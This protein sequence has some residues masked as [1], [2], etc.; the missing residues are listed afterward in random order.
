MDRMHSPAATLTC[1]YFYRQQSG[2]VHS[3]NR[4]SVVPD[5]ILDR[6]ELTGVPWPSCKS[7][8]VN[9]TKDW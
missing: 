4:L 5:A 7:L 6:A 9:S 1:G 3:A 8:P 2:E